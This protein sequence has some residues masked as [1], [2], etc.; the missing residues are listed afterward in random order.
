MSQLNSWDISYSHISFFER[1]L[2]THD[3]VESYTRENDI[4]FRI[5]RNHD[6][7]PVNALLVNVYTVGLADYFRAKDEFPGMNCLV[8]AA[9]WNGYTREAKEQA[10]TDR[11]GLFVAGEF[12]GSLWI[13]QPY[14]Y[15]KKDDDGNPIYY[16]R[17]A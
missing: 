16:F 3:R 4:F 2:R 13:P 15:V 11:V 7:S 6:L 14:R 9:N 17:T 1:V 8:T 5:I 10:G 12:F